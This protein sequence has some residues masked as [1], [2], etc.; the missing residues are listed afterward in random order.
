M[1]RSF[2]LRREGYALAVERHIHR[3]TRIRRRGLNLDSALDAVISVNVSGSGD[4]Q[5]EE[6]RPSP[7]DDRGPEVDRTTPAERDG[8]GER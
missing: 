4:D 5:E 1:G 2:L 8:G 7:R 6:D 3:R